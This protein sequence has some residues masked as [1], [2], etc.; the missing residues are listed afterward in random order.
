MNQKK[1]KNINVFEYRPVRPF[2]QIPEKVLMYILQLTPSS[3]AKVYLYLYNIS[4]GMGHDYTITHTSVREIASN[5]N[6]S[7]GRTQNAITYFKKIGAIEKIES[8]AVI[9]TKFRVNV[10]EYSSNSGNW[11]F[12]TPDKVR[13]LMMKEKLLTSE[14]IV[15]SKIKR[16]KSVKKSLDQQLFDEF[17]E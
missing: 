9:G 5:L 3:F 15:T 16:Y 1:D 10:P 6:I 2:L 11:F 4:Y 14:K 13:Y 17:K 8:R 7:I 12:T